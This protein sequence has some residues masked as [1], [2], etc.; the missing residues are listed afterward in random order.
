MMH[1]SVRFREAEYTVGTQ[2]SILCVFVSMHVVAPRCYYV[3]VC[4]VL[5]YV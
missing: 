3:V 4:A 5:P 2:F 1:L